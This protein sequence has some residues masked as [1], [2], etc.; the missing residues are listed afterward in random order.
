[1]YRTYFLKKNTYVHKE[2]SRRVFQPSDGFPPA[3]EWTSTVYLMRIC[4]SENVSAST[5]LKGKTKQ[6]QK[7]Y[8]LHFLPLKLS[9]SVDLPVLFAL[10]KLFTWQ[11]CTMY[12]GPQKWLGSKMRL[13]LLFSQSFTPQCGRHLCLSLRNLKPSSFF[14]TGQVIW[15]FHFVLKPEQQSL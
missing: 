1:M 8:S 4:S 3:W 6:K 2:K 12:H 10:A 11:K 5:F 14:F 13:Q 7:H 15:I 9:F